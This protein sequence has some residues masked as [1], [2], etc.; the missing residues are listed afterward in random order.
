MRAASGIHSAGKNAASAIMSGQGYRQAIQ[1]PAKTRE[2]WASE[3]VA[4]IIND[5]VAALEKAYLAFREAGGDL[6][7][8][9]CNCRLGVRHVTLNAIE[10]A[11]FHESKSAFLFMWAAASLT[12][13][14]MANGFLDSLR[15]KVNQV[16]AGEPLP[17]FDEE[18]LM[19]LACPDDL[20]TAKR[21]VEEWS[22]QKPDS[23]FQIEWL[24]IARMAVAHYESK[25]LE[26]E[27]GA[28]VYSKRGQ[29]RL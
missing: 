14:D 19:I 8:I 18:I 3:I 15:T 10:M 22:G 4:A 16:P 28:V 1:T 11:H 13:R 9:D 25:E 23:R 20:E 6:E 7:Q 2:Q 5:N 17:R 27:A 24:R 29:A 26:K 21:R 12:N